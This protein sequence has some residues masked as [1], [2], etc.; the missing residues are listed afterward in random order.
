[1][2]IDG[3]TLRCCFDSAND[4]P[5]LH[6]VRAWA[7][8]NRSVLGEVAVDDKSHEIAA[9]PKLLEIL[10]LTGANVTID[11]MGRQ[12]EIAAKAVRRGPTIS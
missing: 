10:E 2:P 3:K 11:A 6:L 12:K 8:E 5:A 7:A 9:I 1:V 4:L